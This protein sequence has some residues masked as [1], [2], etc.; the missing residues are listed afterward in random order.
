[1]LEAQSACGPSPPLLPSPGLR[2]VSSTRVTPCYLCSPDL[3]LFLSCLFSLLDQR[4]H[5][6]LH[7]L[8]SWRYSQ[9]QVVYYQNSIFRLSLS[10]VKLPRGKRRDGKR[11]RDRPA[12]AERCSL[13]ITCRA[14]SGTLF[15]PYP[16]TM[17]IA[18]YWSVTPPPPL[19]RGS[20]R[21]GGA[22]GSGGWRAEWEKSGKSTMSA[23]SGC[24]RS[25]PGLES[26]ASG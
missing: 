18:V 26:N 17:L 3:V 14:I 22:D 19:R 11:G 6:S 24:P 15:S 9:P 16:T 21:G 20:V 5:I 2:F 13:T 23:S 7:S 10:V 4:L 25:V 1:M 12:D 8:L